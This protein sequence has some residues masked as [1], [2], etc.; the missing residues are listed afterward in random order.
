VRLTL[1]VLVLAPVVMR[2]QSAPTSPISRALYIALGADPYSG[3]PQHLPIALSAGLE[4]GRIGSRWTFRLGADYL[5]TTFPYFD[6]REEEYGVAAAGRF[7]RRRGALRPYAL[8]GVGIANLRSRG[9]GPGYVFSP[10]LGYH[11]PVET[12]AYAT[13]RWNGSLL[14]GVGLDVRLGPM[15]LFI[16]QRVNVYPTR[17]STDL[18][19]STHLTKALF[20][21]A[22]F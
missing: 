16:E 4:Q 8:G 1:F 19:Y 2:A 20:L 11:V 17:L 10:E 18:K 5:R 6:R 14:A 13:S 3:S 9:S 21:G 7:G 22:R 15:D 12:M